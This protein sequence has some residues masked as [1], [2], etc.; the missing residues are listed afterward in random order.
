MNI[1]KFK[2]PKDPDAEKITSESFTKLAYTPE[3]VK[4]ISAYATTELIRDDEDV[5]S[6]MEGA[7]RCEEWPGLIK[8]TFGR[9][10]DPKGTKELPAEQQSELG[11]T[12]FQHLESSPDWPACV[13]ASASHPATAMIVTHELTSNLKNHF[14]F[15]S[16]GKAPN[17]IEEQ[18]RILQQMMQD[19]P[20]Q[21]ASIEKVV[22][23]K[24]AELRVAQ[25]ARKNLSTTIE[26]QPEKVFAAVQHAAAAGEEM[27]EKISV[28]RSCGIHPDPGSGKDPIE[29]FLMCSFLNDPTFLTILN[30]MG[31]MNIAANTRMPDVDGTGRIEPCGI[32]TGSDIRDLLATELAIMD[33]SPVLFTHR[34]LNNEAMLMD[35]KGPEQRN[36]GDL[37]LLVD[38]S[39]SMD[40]LRIQWA[41]ALAGVALLRITKDKRRAL[42]NMYDIAN[43]FVSVQNT[44]DLA[45]AFEQLSQRAGGGTGTHGALVTSIEKAAQAGLR[46]P[47][48]LLITDGDWPELSNDVVAAITKTGA[49]FFVIM[50]EGAYH[51]KGATRTWSLPNLTVDNAAAIIQELERT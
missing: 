36:Q 6:M 16:L 22:Q 25:A 26:K 11:Q 39:G 41:R 15:A 31:R 13:I 4:Q 18:I 33:E 40:G 20:Q 46:K 49:R 32:K 29:D 24:T 10:Y 48:Y 50:L 2:Y 30:L 7:P 17:T 27:A 21:A 3:L 8:E 37:V 1:G 5:R 14:D 45:A 23:K 43:A 38:K 9:V 44:K 12:L 42:L 35:R 34:L 47:D 19:N 28:L 51:V